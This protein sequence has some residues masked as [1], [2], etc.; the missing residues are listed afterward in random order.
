[1]G[2]RLKTSSLTEHSSS[3]QKLAPSVT[4]SRTEYETSLEHHALVNNNRTDIASM[5]AYQVNIEWGTTSISM[6]FNRLLIHFRK[7]P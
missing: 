2:R 4:A 6:I 5:K 1:M 3:P 7:M